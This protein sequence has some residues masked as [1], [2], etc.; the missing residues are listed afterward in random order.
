[1]N[2]PNYLIMNPLFVKITKKNSHVIRHIERNFYLFFNSQ[3]IRNIIKKIKNPSNY[4]FYV[5]KHNK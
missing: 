1:M 5:N 3:K 4:K 2:S